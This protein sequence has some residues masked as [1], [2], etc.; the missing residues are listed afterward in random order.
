MFVRQL[1]RP[2][3]GAFQESEPPKWPS[4]NETFGLLNIE[5]WNSQC[6]KLFVRQLFGT[7][8]GVL[9]KANSPKMA[10]KIKILNCST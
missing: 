4:Q 5:S 2:N 10:P 7:N 3:L 1:F 8:V 6:R 9:W